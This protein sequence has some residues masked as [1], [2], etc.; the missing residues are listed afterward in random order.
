MRY[1][2]TMFMEEADEFISELDPK[3]IKKYFTILTLQN[4]PMTQSY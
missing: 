1:F 2:E 3:T 4:R